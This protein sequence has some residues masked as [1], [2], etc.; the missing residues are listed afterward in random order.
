MDSEAKDLNRYVN[1]NYQV[2][3]TEPNDIL[4]DD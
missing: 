2:F 4:P 1:S 3:E